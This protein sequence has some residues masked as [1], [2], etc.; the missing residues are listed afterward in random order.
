V[1]KGMLWQVDDGQML[2]NEINRAVEHYRQKY[3]K[4]PDTVEMHPSMIDEIIK[5]E[6]IKVIMHSSAAISPGTIWIGA[7]VK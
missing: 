5:P 2:E 3:G 7:E 1:K 4:A 6:L